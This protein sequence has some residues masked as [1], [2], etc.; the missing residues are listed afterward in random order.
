MGF[1]STIIVLVYNG[2]KSTIIVLVYNGVKVYYYCISLLLLYKFIMEFK[3]TIIVL[4][5][6]GV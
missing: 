5:Y 1:K 6:N 4:V 3:S 2:F